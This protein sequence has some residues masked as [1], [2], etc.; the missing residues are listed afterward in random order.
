MSINRESF[1]ET[2]K[3]IELTKDDKTYVDVSLSFKPSP[4]TNDITL[5]KNENAI[6]N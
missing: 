3:F 2:N 6:N 1:F 5:L 4:V